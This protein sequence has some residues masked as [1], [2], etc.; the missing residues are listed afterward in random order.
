MPCP[1]DAYEGSPDNDRY[2]HNW[3]GNISYFVPSYFQPASRRD[4]VWI[5]QQAEAQN[6]RV[7]AVGRG[8]SF[9]DCAVSQDWVVDIGRLANT[10]F[11]LTHPATGPTLLSPTWA[12][13][14]F[15]PSN[16]KLY[17]VEAGITIFE[18]NK[19]L[20]TEQLAMLT[21]GRHSPARSPHR[22]TGPI[23]ISHR[24]RA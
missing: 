20:H 2:W 11:F 18:L 12:A 17:H 24:C 22:R 13:R 1:S 6:V 16:E 9:E 7:K 5:L 14:Q 15:G 19:R 21:R 8:W 3:L 23:S 10:I 4:L